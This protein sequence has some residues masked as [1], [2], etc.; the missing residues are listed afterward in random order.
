[1]INPSLN[2]PPH[3]ETIIKWIMYVLTFPI[4]FTQG[5]IEG[6]KKND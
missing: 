3:M 5:F 1:M 4:G 6:W 2:T